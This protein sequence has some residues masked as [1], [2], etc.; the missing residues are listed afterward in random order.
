MKVIKINV[1][2]EYVKH[3]SATALSKEKVIYALID[4]VEKRNS[5]NY[6]GSYWVVSKNKLLCAL[7]NN[8]YDCY[9]F[10]CGGFLSIGYIEEHTIF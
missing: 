3:S 7:T 2:E 1:L 10:K 4:I 5:L 6:E 9:S 8:C